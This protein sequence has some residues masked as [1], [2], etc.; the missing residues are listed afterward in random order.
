MNLAHFK[1]FVVGI[2]V[3]IS[4][5]SYGQKG[6]DMKISKPYNIF[7]FLEV[8]S[9]SS[10]HHSSYFTKII[11]DRIKNDAGFELVKQNFS[12]LQLHY[13]ISYNRLPDNRRSGNSIRD[14]I[15]K[16]LV[17]ADSWETFEK[18]AI[19]ILPNSEF[20]G[21]VDVLKAAEPYYDRVITKADEKKFEGQLKK[22]KTYQHQTQL[23]FQQIR[24]FYNSVW[25]DRFPFTVAFFPIPGKKGD[26]SATPH[27]NSL[28]V[29]ML[30]ETTDYAGTMGVAI[31]E[32]AHVLYHQQSAD[33]QF[34]LDR[35]FKENPSS[36]S[37]FAY[38]FFDESLATAIGNGWAFEKLTGKVDTTEWYNNIYIN[39]FGKAIFPLVKQY[40]NAGKSMDKPFI[41]QVILL[42]ETTFPKAIYDIEMNMNQGAMYFSA[43]S[44]D[45]V[46]EILNELEQYF[47]ISNY[48]ISAPIN[49]P[50]SI[51]MIKE[52]DK[53]NQ[54]Y[55]LTQNK[56][57]NWKSIQNLYPEIGDL[58]KKNG[59]YS[60]CK[61][62]Q[63][64]HF[65]LADSAS[66]LQ[67][68]FKKMKSQVLIDPNQ[69]VQFTLN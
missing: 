37:K 7:N 46:N 38:S 22:M 66:E 44:G 1:T 8:A 52:N 35:Y 31:H 9:R 57:E 4:S 26:L 59:Y 6:F 12:K 5:F 58:P 15:I 61:K 23:M 42:F 10:S 27:V 62:G 48:K 33:F 28:C 36:Y 29:G 30:T 19:G 16:F 67:S 69:F 39:G 54:L 11:D 53:N 25:S 65:I 21:L 20:V 50:R 17:E 45:E 51:E 18:R 60:I 64:Q 47:K 40:L 63:I 43:G 3:L 41:D 14:L 13:P 34:E 32:M 56:L 49:D 68:I 2:F 24:G 55:I